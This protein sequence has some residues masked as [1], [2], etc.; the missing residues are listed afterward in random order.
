MTRKNKERNKKKEEVASNFGC[1]NCQNT[2][3]I[4]VS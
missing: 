1:N 3:I 2:V 4:Q